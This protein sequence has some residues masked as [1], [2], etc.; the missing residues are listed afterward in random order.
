MKLLRRLITVK[1]LQP[2][3]SLYP[4]GLRSLVVTCWISGFEWKWLRLNMIKNFLNNVQRG[5][6]RD[7]KQCPTAPHRGRAVCRQFTLSR[8]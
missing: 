5:D 7:D 4:A 2:A 1:R 3:R 8:K 6:L